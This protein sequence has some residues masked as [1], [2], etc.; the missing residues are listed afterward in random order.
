MCELDSLTFGSSAFSDTKSHTCSLTLKLGSGGGGDDGP[1]ELGTAERILMS[2]TRNLSRTSE[3]HEGRG[4][5]SEHGRPRRAS[6]D[7]YQS[8]REARQSTITRLQRL[9]T[10]FG[11]FKDLLASRNGSW[12]KLQ[13]LIEN[14]GKVTI[15]SQ[16]GVHKQP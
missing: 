11:K 7:R 1:N 10:W 8:H 5:Q 3:H 12:E 4:G 9:N 2:G 13:G 15:K 6:S 14:Q 16:K